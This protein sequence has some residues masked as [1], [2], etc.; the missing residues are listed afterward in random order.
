MKRQKE[1]GANRAWPSWP[2][3]L[4]VYLFAILILVENSLASDFIN[5]RKSEILSTWKKEMKTPYPTNEVLLASQYFIRDVLAKNQQFVMTNEGTYWNALRSKYGGKQTSANNNSLKFL[6]DF[7][8][9][10]FQNLK[11]YRVPQA[12]NLDKFFADYLEIVNAFCNKIPDSTVIKNFFETYYTDWLVSTTYNHDYLPRLKPVLKVAFSDLPIS[13][14]LVSATTDSLE[15]VLGEPEKNRSKIDSIIKSA[16]SGFLKENKTYLT[17]NLFSG[18]KVAGLINAFHVGDDFHYPVKIGAEV[19]EMSVLKLW[20]IDNLSIGIAVPGYYYKKQVY[21]FPDNQPYAWTDFSN[22]FHG[23]KGFPF[24]DIFV[25]DTTIQSYF[26]NGMV[27]KEGFDDLMSYYK[28]F[29]TTEGSKFVD[30]IDRLCM[31]PSKFT[32]A[33][34]SENLEK[35]LL[36]H[37]VVG[38]GGTFYN[39]VMKEPEVPTFEYH[40]DAEF[41]AYILQFMYSPIQGFDLACMF[42]HMANPISFSNQYGEAYLRICSE[43]LLSMNKR[44]DLAGKLKEWSGNNYKDSISNLT[45]HFREFDNLNYKERIQLCLLPLVSTLTGLSLEDRKS[46]LLSIYE[47]NTKKPIPEPIIA[48]AARPKQQQ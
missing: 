8:W 25:C 9:Y 44:R 6:Y 7:N 39:G 16:N 3:T 1:L 30:A 29:K 43:L 14:Q 20:C 33:D 28:W 35:S 27:S 38:H 48:A 13:M 42:S 31:P 34:W 23:K 36:L 2:C 18:K 5:S 10:V 17:F 15:R 45:K 40:V 24:L 46:L 11:K 26:D 37:E 4:T 12:N 47:R 32:Y 41:Y 21:I 19:V 22:Y